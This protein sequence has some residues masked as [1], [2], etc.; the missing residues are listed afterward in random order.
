M[1]EGRVTIK[2]AEALRLIDQQIGERVYLALFIER[3]ASESGEKGPVPFLEKVGRLVK[4][5]RRWC[6]ADPDRPDDREHRGQPFRRC[7]TR[8]RI[9][10]HPSRSRRRR[11]HRR[12]GRRRFP[13][14][15]HGSGRTGRRPRRRPPLCPGRRQGPPTGMPTGRRTRCGSPRCLRSLGDRMS[16]T[17]DVRGRGE[18]LT[19]FLRSRERRAAERRTG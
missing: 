16:R 7:P 9:R 1:P 11:P 5:H 3:A 12:E 6:E 13:R 8:R 15:R 17:V 2:H 4:Q 14:R 10:Q 18:H 19:V